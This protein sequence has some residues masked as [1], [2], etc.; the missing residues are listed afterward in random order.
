MLL[1]M[2]ML[3]DIMGGGGGGGVESGERRNSFACFGIKSVL[4]RSLRIFNKENMALRGLYCH[5]INFLFNN[6]L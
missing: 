2:M 4:R 6:F 3:N 1:N 5:F